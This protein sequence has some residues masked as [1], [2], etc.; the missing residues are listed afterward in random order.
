MLV[1][2]IKTMSSDSFERLYRRILREK[3]FTEVLVTGRSADGGIDG[4]GVL[5]V[6]L[7]D[8]AK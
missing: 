4:A 6:N 8:A 3:G 7:G 2:V 5:R 1:G